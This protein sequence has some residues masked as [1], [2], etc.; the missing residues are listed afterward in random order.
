MNELSKRAIFG[1]LYVG[2]ILS[3]L[4]LEQ[5]WLY[6]TVFSLFIVQGIWEYSSLA[7]ANRTRI[8]RT[9]LDGLMGVYL[10]VS[11]YYLL[12]DLSDGTLNLRDLILLAPYMS[13]LCYLLIGAVY[14]E[15]AG[16]PLELAKRVFGQVYVALPYVAM[17]LIYTLEGSGLLL[18]C[19][20]GVWLND[21]G[22]YLVG[23]QLG[24]RKLFP[25]V[26]PKK[27]WEG[28][29]GGLL[30]TVLGACLIPLWEAPIYLKIILGVCITLAS[31]WGDLFE[32]VLKR[33]AGV[34]DSG[35]L[36]P[37]HGGILDRTDSLLF[38]FPVVALY[39]LLGSWLGSGVGL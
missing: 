7:G 10:F 11:S 21:T 14:S 37:G 39:L 2:L 29:W 16:Q 23:S 36:I 32:S 24:K 25:S 33:N 6:L 20:V 34:K 38:V 26:S 5:T 28:F 30:F 13:Y 35:T 3:A 18:I 4:L 22:A 19:F 1:L 15:R 17:N 12:Q 27:S 9:L 31:T 8:L